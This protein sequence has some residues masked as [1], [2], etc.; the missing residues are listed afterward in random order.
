MFNQRV[1]WNPPLP[2]KK[3]KMGKKFYWALGDLKFPPTS[4]GLSQS[5]GGGV[6]FSTL[7]LEGLSTKF[8]KVRL[9]IAT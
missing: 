7:F 6:K 2:P 5:G 1:L 4:G 8:V 3:K 9:L